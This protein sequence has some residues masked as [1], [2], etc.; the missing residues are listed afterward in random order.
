MT[1]IGG[2][3]ICDRCREEHYTICDK[4]DEW[5]EKCETIDGVCSECR[6]NEEESA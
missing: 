6:E 5:V 4:C 2:R 3:N 1:V